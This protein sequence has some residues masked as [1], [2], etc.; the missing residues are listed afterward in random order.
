LL[1]RSLEHDNPIVLLRLACEWLH[2]AKLLRP[3]LGHLER[4]V[5][6]TRAAAAGELHRRVRPLLTPDRQTFLDGL[7]VTD[8]KTGRTPL[9]VLRTIG[10]SNK[11][12]DIL[13]ALERLA[14][15]KDAGVEGWDLSDINPNRLKVLA[16]TGGRAT[17]QYLQRLAPQRRHP[18]LLAFL[19]QAIVDVTDEVLH[20]FESCLWEVYGKACRAF[21]D[22]W[23]KLRESTNEKLRWFQN[24]GDVVLDTAVSDPGVRAAIFQR[25]SR[26]KLTQAIEE[27]AEIV[28][29]KDDGHFDFFATHYGYFRRFV[30]RFL[31]LLEFE[32][33]SHHEALLIA[34]GLLRALDAA[35]ASREI[36]STAPVDFIDEKWRPYVLGEE[37]RPRRRYY[38]L[39]ILWQ[40]REALRAGNVWVPTSRR[41]AALETYLIPRHRWPDLRS[42]FCRMTGTPEDGAIRLEE[43]ERTLVARLE[44][45]DQVLVDGTDAIRVEDGA[46]VVTPIEAEDRPATAVALE[47]A[48]AAL[49]PPVDLPD[50]LIEVDGWTDFS[51]RFRHAGG[52]SRR[53][54]DILSPL[55]ASLVGPR[56]QLWTPTDGEHR[57]H[58][59]RPAR[60]VHY[61]VPA[62]GFAPDRPGGDRRPP[63]PPATDPDLGWRDALVLG[64]PALP[65]RQQRPEGRRPTTVLRLQE[66]ADLLHLDLGP[67]LPVRIQSRPDDH[68]GR[69]V[70]PGRD[71]RQRDRAD[72]P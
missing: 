37:A 54:G 53:G 49:L 29:P 72:D 44:R 47:N 16:R 27:T 34:V 4:W 2:R 45:L 50:L 10:S 19:R 5:A 52:A 32:G 69:H 14:V 9:H 41:Y 42:E 23:S 38:E 66:G 11:A 28:R 59:L 30:P 36:P 39:C 24:I 21:D 40:L 51:S 56:L 6:S 3:R 62:G 63:S 17:N 48:L 15:L 18:I 46:L 58:P 64:R 12:K 71:P 20:M 57:R 67:V 1:D 70:R 22:H 55:Y 25:V 61:L 33:S 8:P 68:P 7:L 13:I 65:G 26:A 35:G 43:R 60:V 31:E